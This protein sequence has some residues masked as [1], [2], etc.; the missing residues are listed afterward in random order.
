MYN[1]KIIQIT[2]QAECT[3]ECSSKCTRTTFTKFINILSEIC[4]EQQPSRQI[5]DFQQ[6][7]QHYIVVCKSLFIYLFVYLF[8]FI[9]KPFHNNIHTL[10]QKETTWMDT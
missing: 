3:T 2:N 4:Y 7:T 10:Y 9:Q 5:I 6:A 1:Q 8:Y